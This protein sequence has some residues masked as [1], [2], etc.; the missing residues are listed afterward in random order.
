MTI[1]EWIDRGGRPV[2]APLRMS[3]DARGTV[4]AEALLRAAERQASIGRT[5]LPRS[6]AAA[7]SLLGADAYI[8]YACLWTVRQGGRSRDLKS[9]AARVAGGPWRE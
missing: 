1:G 3:L 6:R 5:G 4:S 2:P 7:F 8:T 9:M